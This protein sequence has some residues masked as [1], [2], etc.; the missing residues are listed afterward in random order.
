MIIYI[1]TYDTGDV[2]GRCED[3]EEPM[4]DT[5]DIV[6]NILLLQNILRDLLCVGEGDGGWVDEW[7]RE[8]G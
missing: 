1:P 6:Q 5:Q 4:Q 8:P 7:M 2:M 3:L